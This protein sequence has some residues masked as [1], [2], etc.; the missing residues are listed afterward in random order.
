MPLNDPSIMEDPKRDTKTGKFVKGNSSNLKFETAED[1]LDEAYAYL[2]ETEANPVKVN[3]TEI[4]KGKPVHFKAEKNKIPTMLGLSTYLEVSYNA[5][6]M[7]VRGDGPAHM[8]E[9]ANLI[10]DIIRTKQ[11]EL[12]ASGAVNPAFA[13]RLLGLAEKVENQVTEVAKP[14]NQQQPDDVPNLV[15]P[16]AP[17]QDQLSETPLLFSKRQ[18]DAGVPYPMKTINAEPSE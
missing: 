12:G 15:H 10:R 1:F 7:W 9:P 8:E 6:C 13:Q 2:A 16:D 3:S 18:I 14:E 11:I 5:L 4:I 17:I